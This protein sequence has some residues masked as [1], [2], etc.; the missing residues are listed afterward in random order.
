MSAMPVILRGLVFTERQNKENMKLKKTIEVD[1]IEVVGKFAVQVR[2]ATVITETQE[3]ENG[4]EIAGSA[5]ELSRSNHRHVLHPSDDW[6]AKDEDGK[7]IQDER[8][9][10]ICDSIF[11]SSVKDEWVIQQKKTEV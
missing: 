5:T 3:D 6:Q 1:K 4:D 2:T 11:T 9:R 7:Y 10:H 8:V